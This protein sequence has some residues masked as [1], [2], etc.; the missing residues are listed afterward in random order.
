MTDRKRLFALI[1]IMTGVSLA[2]AAIA[3]YVLYGAAF[4]EASDRLVETAQS[5][6]RLVEAVARFDSVHTKDF[7][8]GH[9]SATLAQIIDAHEHYQ[10]FGRTGEFTLARREG[11]QIVFVLSHRHDDLENPKPV[12]WNSEIAEPMRRALNGRSGTCI[13]LDYRGQRVL[14]AHEPVSELDMGIVA[15][16]DLAEVRTPFVTASLVTLGSAAVVVVLGSLLFVYVSNPMIRRLEEL[17]DELEDRVR[18]RTSEL[19]EAHE[20]LL[21]KERLATLGQLSGGVAHEIRNPLGVI[22]NAVYFLQQ[23]QDDSDEDAR[24]C[25]KG[26]FAWP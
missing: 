14:A 12:P 8:G 2:V 7:P 1:L 25:T 10:G 11:E 21:R 6:A 9:A 24:R 13:A 23:V 22:R 20:Q 15:K 16:I 5:Q 3:I 26:D 18:Q 4:D 19:S 17:N